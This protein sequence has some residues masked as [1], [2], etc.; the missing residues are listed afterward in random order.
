ML[1]FFLHLFSIQSAVQGWRRESTLI[2]QFGVFWGFKVISSHLWSTLSAEHMSYFLLFP[3]SLC[4]EMKILGEKRCSWKLGLC[5]CI[6]I[7]LFCHVQ[8]FQPCS[9]WM[10]Y[11]LRWSVIIHHFGFFPVTVLFLKKKKKK[12]Y[13][14]SHQFAPWTCKEIEAFYLEGISI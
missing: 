10:F 1:A 13:Y 9:Q 3:E 11:Q 12:S 8:L 2:N 5:S 7:W 4:L 6:N 14:L